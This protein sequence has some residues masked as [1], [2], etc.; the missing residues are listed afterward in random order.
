MYLDLSFTLKVLF[1]LISFM[2]AF[3]II[4]IALLLVV[5]KDKK[6]PFVPVILTV[7]NIVFYFIVR[8]LVKYEVSEPFWAAL[9]AW[10]CVYV[11]YIK[12]AFW[13]VP[14]LYPL[15]YNGFYLDKFYTQTMST[16]YAKIA[17]FSNLIDTKF[18]G[19]YNL[20]IN[21]A[22]C[23][24]KVSDW[25]EN[26]VMNGAVRLTTGIAKMFSKLY[27]VAQNG[28]IQRYNAYAFIIITVIISCLIIGYVWLYLRYI[29]G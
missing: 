10:I 22:K 16:I 25:V 7:L 5:N 11:L 3:Y 28:N 20:L 14:V 29:G 4:R 17:D 24:V 8:K 23:G 15:A 13:K 21:S 1:C 6:I 2:T 18:F 19:N 26:N 12:D 27:L 9:T